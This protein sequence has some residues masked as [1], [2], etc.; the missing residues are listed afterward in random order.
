M[1]SVALL[2]P[3]IP[4]NAGAIIRLCANTGTRLHFIGPMGFRLDDRRLARVGLDYGDLT[5]VTT[6]IDWN[7]YLS[8]TDSDRTFALTTRGS[9]RYDQVAF[10]QED[11][12][13]FGAESTGLPDAVIAA[14]PTARRVRLPMIE[15]SRSLNLANAVAVVVFEAWRQLGFPGARSDEARGSG[16]PGS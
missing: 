15:G 8:S 7:R 2:R 4:Q 14:I 1:L 13:L 9:V 11:T 16:P 6:H 10:A 12:L 3:E 5:S